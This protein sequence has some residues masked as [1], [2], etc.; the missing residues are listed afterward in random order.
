[1]Y[2]INV[3]SL[4][5]NKAKTQKNYVHYICILNFIFKE[6]KGEYYGQSTRYS[7]S[8]NFF[9]EFAFD[10]LLFWQDFLQKKLGYFYK[11]F[12]QNTI[13]CN[14]LYYLLEKK[15]GCIAGMKIN[16]Y[17]AEGTLLYC[18]SASARIRAWTNDL[19][20]QRYWQWEAT[21]LPTWP[22]RH[23]SI[24]IKFWSFLNMVIIIEIINILELFIR[25]YKKILDE[26][27]V[28]P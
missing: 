19:W 2:C 11:W 6:Q 7:I 13:V 10:L 5:I 8:Y 3:G 18:W 9:K 12:R 4:I 26:R 17:T 1:M 20:I 22:S 25:R 14:I 28:W 24:Y 21:V 27:V 23:L 16:E 15:N